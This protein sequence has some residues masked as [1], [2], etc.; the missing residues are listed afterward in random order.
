M[1][2]YCQFK[3]QIKKIYSTKI[4]YL[5]EI[6]CFNKEDI[7]LDDTDRHSIFHAIHTILQKI[8]VDTLWHEIQEIYETLLDW[9]NNYFWYHSIGLLIT[10]NEINKST[11]DAKLVMTLYKEYKANNKENFKNF[12]INKIVELYGEKTF[13]D[14]TLNKTIS[15]LNEITYEKKADVKRILL[16]YNIALLINANN[17]YERFPFDL[18]KGDHW[19]IEHINPQT[20]K[21]ANENE[22]K[23][24]LLSYKNF[25]KSISDNSKFDSN[26]INKIEDQINEYLNGNKIIK[27]DQLAEQIQNLLNIK[28]NDLLNNLVLLDSSTNR[29]YKNK[30]FFEKRKIIISEERNHYFFNNEPEQNSDKYIPIGTKWVFLK[31]FEKSEQLIVWAEEDKN[32]YIYDIAKSINKLLGGRLDG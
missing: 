32:E 14:Q 27:F 20:P 13:Q 16:I 18:Y 17:T 5:F 29:G 26:K 28:D 30:C 25:I 11:P 23:A 10:E 1:G 4:D 8:E 7:V 6:W 24:W 31:G 9:Y 12:L 19:D 22:I 3:Q 2:F 21:E 15:K